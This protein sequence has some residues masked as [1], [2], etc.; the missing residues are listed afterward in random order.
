MYVCPTVYLPYD[1]EIPSL[2]TVGVDE[3]EICRALE[4]VAGA[5]GSLSDL[6]TQHVV[7]A[8]ELAGRLVQLKTLLDAVL[9]LVTA[10]IDRLAEMITPK[11]SAD[12][13][14]AALKR[15]AS[16]GNFK[17]TFDNYVIYDHYFRVLRVASM[18]GAQFAAQVAASWRELLADLPYAVLGID[19][20]TALLRA[21]RL[22]FE[23]IAPVFGTAVAGQTAPIDEARI[24]PL[25]PQPAP[26]DD[27]TIAFYRW[28][29]GHHIFDLCAIFCRD[30]LLR[31]IQAVTDGDETAIVALL[32]EARQLLRAT[33]AAMWYTT[34]FPLALYRDQLRP[35]MSHTGA[36]GG[37]SGTQNADYERMKTTKE[38]LKEALFSHFGDDPAAWP[39]AVY[40]AIVRFNEIDI[41][42]TEHH[43]LIAAAKVDMDESLAQMAWQPAQGTAS[44]AVEALR[45]MAEAARQDLAERFKPKAMQL[46]FGF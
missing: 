40:G 32:G 30:R 17:E 11:L 33:T 19:D 21:C 35:S 2:T 43:I 27:A 38:Q 42:D 28:T 18:T 31:V 5:A 4:Q 22:M 45:D 8:P 25:A 37:F 15:D 29:E 6:L 3:P 10:Q 13:V 39:A 23:S 34:N 14:E 9:P 46:G 44:N 12:A 1:S 24:G 36:H 20:I 7:F 26:A 41:E 16:A